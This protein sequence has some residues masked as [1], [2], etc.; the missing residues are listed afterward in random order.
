MNT[1]PQSSATGESRDLSDVVERHRSASGGPWSRDR[2]TILDGFGHPVA[3]MGFTAFPAR[4]PQPWHG[5]DADFIAHAWDDIRR[6]L[7]EVERLR[8]EKARMRDS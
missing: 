8:I 5:R 4:D 7:H 2:D 6:L 3:I 1:H